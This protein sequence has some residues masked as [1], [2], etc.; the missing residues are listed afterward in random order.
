MRK[1]NY[2]IIWLFLVSAILISILFNL[3]LY[4]YVLDLWESGNLNELYQSNRKRIDSGLFMSAFHFILFFL[5]AI[6]NYVWKIK[7]PEA[8]V[9]KILKVLLLIGMNVVV[10]FGISSLEYILFKATFDFG[11]KIIPSNYFLTS[12]FPIGLIGI[13]Q[14]YILLLLNR[15]KT[16][17]LE[18]TRLREEK[19]NAEL[20]ALKDQIGPHFFFNTLSSLS[21]V[22][23]N[24]KREVALEFIQE[25]SNTYRYTL[26]SKQQDLVSLQEELEFVRSY[27]FLLKKRFGEKLSSRINIPAEVLQQ[28]IPPMSL[29][30]LVEN[31]VQHNV[32]TQRAP[33]FIHFFIDNDKI[34]VEN[35]LQEKSH[36][37]GL[38]LGLENL[39]NRYYLLAQ[40]EIII[41]RD[42]G[43]FRVK[44]PL[45]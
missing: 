3:K 29:Q 16:A 37:N 34:V 19:T 17:E 28:V 12:N 9:P 8:W 41:E 33:L 18:K 45:L 43:F 38:G 10:F 15:V 6:G 5:L 25:M 1:T 32:M 44:L 2:A 23:Q 13:A 27:L 26:A 40:K 14:A 4:R 30:I 22:V 39:S 35:N 20:A 7:L 42:E 31:A 11:P 24:E 36:S 21:A